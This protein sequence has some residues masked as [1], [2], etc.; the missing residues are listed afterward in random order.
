MNSL[1]TV[2]EFLTGLEERK[3]SYRLEHNRP[4]T[5]MVLLAVP[6]ERWEV[7]FFP[8]GNVELEV[9]GNSVGVRSARVQEIL[10][11]LDKHAA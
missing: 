5:L 1:E 9:F 10:L 8:D 4:D 3:I 2:L 7:E 6:G 11:R